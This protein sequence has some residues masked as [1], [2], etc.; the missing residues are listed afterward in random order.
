MLRPGYVQGG[1]EAN[2]GYLLLGVH[3]R[4]IHSDTTAVC[5]IFYFFYFE[6][7]IRV[8]S[9]EPLHAKRPLIL[10]LV[11]FTAAQA[12]IFF[13]KPYSI[14]AGVTSIVLWI[15]AWEWRTSSFR[16]PNQNRAALWRIFSLNESAPANRKTGFYADRDPNKQ[17]V[18]SFLHKAAQNFELLLNIQDQK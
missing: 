4:R 16:N 3:H 17:E 15:A 10:L 18:G 7:F 11:R 12:V 1:Q 8:Q 2:S 13:A 14:N 6:Y 9:S 5:F